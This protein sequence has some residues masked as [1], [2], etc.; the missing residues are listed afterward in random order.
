MVVWRICK[1]K[2]ARSAFQGIGAEKAGGRWDFRGSRVVYASENLSLATLE[3]LVHVDPRALPKDLVVVLAELP[4]GFSK[5][6]LDVSALP[7]DW[8]NYP[9]PSELKRIGTDWINS[10]NSLALVVPSAVNPVD[11][12]VL[13]NP[14]HSEMIKV[15]VE[16]PEIFDF[17]PRMFK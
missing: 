5:T 11:R 8:R 15:K 12:N 6:E 10:N 14:N 4:K 13:L 16:P 2:Y 9:A 3:L 7:D 1:S 17:D